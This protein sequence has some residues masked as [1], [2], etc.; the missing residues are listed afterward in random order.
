MKLLRT[1]FNRQGTALAVPK[2]RFEKAASA[3]EGLSFEHARFSAR[4]HRRALLVAQALLPVLFF[5]APNTKITRAQDNSHKPKIRAVTAFI[6]LD[7][8]QYE[9]QVQET[10]KFL[11]QAKSAFEKAGYDVETIGIT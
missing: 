9:S 11:H 10:L 2:S 5:L 8:A 6:R 1:L 3:A 4:H 7:R